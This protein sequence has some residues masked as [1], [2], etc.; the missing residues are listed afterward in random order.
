[1]LPGSQQV[2]RFMMMDNR[3][4]LP[5][6]KGLLN[7]IARKEEEKENGIWK[8]VVGHNVDYTTTYSQISRQ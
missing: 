6:D 4:Q 8:I 3:F 1:M 2:T 5:P 7:V